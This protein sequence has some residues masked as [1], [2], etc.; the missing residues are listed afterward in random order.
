MF[1]VMLIEDSKSDVRL[2][3]E[4]LQKHNLNA[5]IEVV[6]DG[7]EA[8]NRIQRL[9]DRPSEEHPQL[10]LLDLNMPRVDGMEVL[11]G[12]RDSPV[13]ARVPVV[14]MSSTALPGEFETALEP[15]GRYFRKPV[16]LD[17]FM[18][19][20]ALVKSVIENQPGN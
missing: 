10:V 15:G 17:D 20:G 19:L 18:K 1:R 16:D 8:L 2:V 4:A 13:S 11:K 3:L 5:S 6:A 7:D 9:Q 14:V 12:I